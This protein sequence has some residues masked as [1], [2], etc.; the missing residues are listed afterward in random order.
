MKKFFPSLSEII[1][2]FSRE[3]ASLIRQKMGKNTSL[4]LSELIVFLQQ[5]TTAG[6]YQMCTTST[7]RSGH[8]TNRLIVA[9]FSKA[10]Q[11][12]QEYLS[13]G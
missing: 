8:F 4:P 13:M 12:L 6:K 7:I 1:I 2:V 5:I 9:F 3:G 10:N 11:E